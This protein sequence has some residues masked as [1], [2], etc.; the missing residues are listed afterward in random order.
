MLSYTVSLSLEIIKMKLLIAGASGFIGHELICALKA[1]HYIAVLGRNKAALQREFPKDIACYSWDDLAATDANQFDAVINL[2]GLNIATSR[3]TPTIKKQIIDSRVSTTE[4]LG[5]WLSKYN[6]KPRFLCANAVGIYGAQ[7]QD[8]ATAF[9]EDAIIDTEHPQD[10]LSEIGVRWQAA[11][12]PAVDAGIPV[13]STRFGVVLRKGQGMLKKLFPSFYLGLGSIVGNGK[14]VISWVHVDDVVGGILFLLE[15]T[16]LT[17]A[18]NL[19]SPY[20]VTQAEFARTLADC[21]HR[22]LLLKMPAFL[23][24]LLFGEMGEYLLL[25]GQRVVPKRL[26]ESGYTFKYPKLAQALQH[27]FGKTK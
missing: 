16:E 13:I 23:I 4:I 21:L 20:P 10:F 19:T 2:C 9:D 24:R 1:K 26:A 3:W 15:H 14:Q 17:G 7:K 12:Q 18:F 27:E 25:K 11:L 6:A 8:D 22:P 5:S